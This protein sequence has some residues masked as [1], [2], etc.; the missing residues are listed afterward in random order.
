VGY[1]TTDKKFSTY[2]LNWELNYT[3]GKFTLKNSLT[4]GY[5]Y[6]YY[7]NEVGAKSISDVL[8]LSFGK[9]DFTASYTY[10]VVD[11]VMVADVYSDTYGY[12]NNPYTSYS[13]SLSYKLLSKPVTKAGLSH[14]FL[15]YTYKSPL[16]YTPFDRNLT[17]GFVSLYY[18]LKRFYFYGNFSYNF[19][20]EMYF[21][22]VGNGQ[23]FKEEM[24]DV[25]NWSA[26]IEIGY[27]KDPFSISVGG[28]NFYNPFY[29]NITGFAAF[30]VHF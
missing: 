1:T 26:N 21:E 8:S 30:K 6:Y 11:T 28:S 10:G 20:T 5:D 4:A 16:Y 18:E 25:D 24:V 23:N 22:Q 17:G 3:F 2:G 12:V 19:G 7:W 29:R 27:Q 13:F 14:S 9:L 15:D